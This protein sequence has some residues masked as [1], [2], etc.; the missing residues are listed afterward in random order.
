MLPPQIENPRYVPDID[1]SIPCV[2]IT[3]RP[4]YAWRGM[5]LDSCRHFMSTNVVKQFIDFIAFYKKKVFNWHLTE[6]QGWRIEIKKYPRLTEISAWRRGDDGQPYGGYYTQE[7]IR[8][9]VAYARARHI[10]VVP[11]IEMPGHAIAVLAAYPEFSCSGGPFEVRT[12]WGISEDVFCAGN[13][14]TFGFLEDVLSEVINLFPGVYVHIGGDECPK[15]R[16]KKCGQCQARIVA[17]GLQDEHELQS[18]FIKRVEKFLTANNRRLI[19]WDEILEGGLAPQATVMSWRGE[20]GGIA[21]AGQNHDVVMSPG[22][23]CYFDMKQRDD[24]DERGHTWAGVVTLE[25]VY[26]YEPTPAQLT[27]QQ[28]RHILGAQANV[29][30]EYIPT[31]N[32]VEYMTL[33][34]MCA[35]AEVVWSPKDRRDWSHFNQRLQDQY[36]RFDILGVNYYKGNKTP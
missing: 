16:W 30:T 24:P 29:W 4:R 25:K 36:R 32:E 17:E 9:I 11:E 12:T 13:D 22:P 10:T 20:E 31:G 26:S 14:A 33:P 35:L 15:V 3:D 8:D 21:A 19:G 18:Y 6:D 5:H 34:R 28:A 2:K 1:W 23:F 27:P 7:D